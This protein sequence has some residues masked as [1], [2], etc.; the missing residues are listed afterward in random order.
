MKNKISL[1]HKF[2]LLGVIIDENLNFKV[3]IEAAVAKLARTT[4]ILYKIKNSLSRQAK[5]NYYYGFIYPFLTYNI[6]IWGSTNS[7]HL[8]PLI[9]Q[10][11]RIIRLLS[12]TNYLDHTTPL[13]MTLIF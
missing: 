11:K 2:V 3:H 6:L 4:G 12:G 13:F 9:I 5:L 7:I 1:S 8:K 10:Q